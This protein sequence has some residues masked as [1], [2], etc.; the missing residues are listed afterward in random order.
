MA[1]AYSPA[2]NGTTHDNTCKKYTSKDSVD[3]AT[4]A[5]YSDFHCSR[6]SDPS[7]PSM[8]IQVTAAVAGVELEEPEYKHYEDNEMPE[9][10][11]ISP[12]GRIPASE[13]PTASTWRKALPS[14]SAVPTILAFAMLLRS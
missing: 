11:L 6:A 10:F 8:V 3:M 13:A 1:V 14:F 7:S 9:F 2:L 5:P 4:G 12:H